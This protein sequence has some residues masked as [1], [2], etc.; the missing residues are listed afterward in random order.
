MGFKPARSSGSH[1]SSRSKLV[2]VQKFKGSIVQ[3]RYA[4][5]INRLY[6]EAVKKLAHGSTSSPR[7]D[8][9]RQTFAHYLG[10]KDP[11]FVVGY[12]GPEVDLALLRGG[13]RLPDR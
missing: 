7:T 2:A 1:G 5:V 9:R 10:L 12:S 3:C 8:F 13:D 6:S 11:K 4:S